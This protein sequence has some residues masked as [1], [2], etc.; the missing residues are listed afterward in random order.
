MAVRVFIVSGTDYTVPANYA[1]PSTIEVIGAGG[2]GGGGDGSTGARAGGG[3]GA[4]ARVSSPALTPG[5]VVTIQ[6]G[7]GGTGPSGA[8]GNHG[9]DAWF[10]GAS[11]AASL[12]GAQAGQGGG[13]GGGGPYTG[14]V[15]GRDI[16]SK[17]STLYDGGTGGNSPNGWN[18]G[19]GGG[20]GGPNGTGAAGGASISGGGAGG[21]GGGGN[22]GGSAAANSTGNGS[23]GGHNFG[24]TGGGAGGT[25]GST[26]STAG[27]AGTDGGGGGGGGGV[28]NGNI[29]A[30][31]GGNGSTGT[32]WDATHGSGG[33]GGGAGGTGNG[34]GTTS[35]GGHGG[36]YGAGGGGGSYSGGVAGGTGGQ[37][38]IVLTYEAGGPTN[39]PLTVTTGALTLTG[40][41]TTLTP[42]QP[43]KTLTV[44]AGALALTGNTAGLNYAGAIAATTLDPAETSTKITL[45]NGNLTATRTSGSG[46]GTTLS[47]PSDGTKVYAEVVTNVGSTAQW[48]F[49]VTI[50]AFSVEAGILGGSAGTHGASSV[51]YFDDGSVYKDGAEQGDG[52]DAPFVAG[53]RVAVAYNAG[54]GQITFRNVTTASAWT[55]SIASPFALNTPLRFGFSVFSTIGSQATFHFDDTFVGTPPDSSYT[56]WNGTAIPTTFDP[57]YTHANIT[58]S[59]GNKTATRSSTANGTDAATLSYEIAASATKVY[60]EAT[61]NVQSAPQAWGLANSSANLGVF[62]GGD[63]NGISAFGS[64][65]TTNS[66]PVAVLPGTAPVAGEVLAIAVNKTAQTVAFRNVTQAAA[67]SSAVSISAITG[68]WRFS[69][70]GALAG[71]QLTANFDDTFVGT[72]PDGSYTRWNGTPIGVAGAYNLTVTPGSLALTGNDAALPRTIIL[73]ATTAALALTGSAV[74]FLRGFAL[75]VTTAALTLTGT[76]AN[77]VRGLRLAVNTLALSL[78]GNPVVLLGG[79]TL[80]AT[81]GALALTG[82]T[83]GFL[84]GVV[85]AATSGALALT[86]NAA[87][88]LRGTVLAATSGVLALTGTAVDLVTSSAR[89]LTVLTGELALTGNTA[90]LLLNR[91]LIAAQGA[92]TLT[93][94]AASL[95]TTYTLAAFNGTLTL[96][97][98]DVLLR[99][100]RRIAA[101]LGE[102]LLTGRPVD[103]VFYVPQH[104][105][106]AVEPGALVLLSPRVELRINEKQ[107]GPMR[108]GRRLVVIPGR[109]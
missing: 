13:N 43:H 63:N 17:G 103:L 59:N 72:P 96:T 84:R 76:A 89:T 78:S 52:L 26:A 62:I 42:A 71:N 18:G 79:K 31:P 23:A 105:K 32:E 102:L 20:A 41:T 73:V 65:I 107:P 34:F 100:A 68:P 2:G 48:V 5:A 77:L 106:L 87:N 19:G 98:V 47:T 93:G 108:W 22:G 30:S 82:N 97:G 86:G 27:A 28:G 7:A 44:T 12:V 55:A 88:L 90:N 70:N 92:L 57:T 21:G 1:T 36:L 101:E 61:I 33:G 64:Q 45:S 8:V 67:W 75:A 9:T 16:N 14:G 85:L 3:G 24:G 38:I 83:A 53:D 60:A 35:I 99:S 94:N 40:N 37:S 15:R 74:D 81:S 29:P 4:Y 51:A 46:Y 6:V 50:D 80:S 39:Y 91:L 11:L 25:S 95:L 69:T 49:G 66:V 104:Y 58:L 109:W 54:A 10:N 56:R